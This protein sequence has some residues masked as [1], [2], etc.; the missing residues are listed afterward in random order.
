MFHG[1]EAEPPVPSP[2]C[3]H[4][5]LLPTEHRAPVPQIEA[6]VLAPS[7]ARSDTQS[8]LQRIK[9]R[10]VSALLD[11]RPSPPVGGSCADGE[12]MSGDRL[13]SPTNPRFWAGSPLTV[14]APTSSSSQGAARRQSQPPILVPHT[15]G[16]R[17]GLNQVDP[18]KMSEAA[19]SRR[20]RRRK[21]QTPGVPAPMG[22]PSTPVIGT[23]PATELARKASSATKRSFGLRWC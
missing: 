22:W 8:H 3:R 5:Y 12:M 21:V 18:R 11:P 14:S 10:P 6:K 4:K 20:A 16:G 2:Y 1:A 9:Q 15:Q 23:M 17:E 13:A 7:T 19:F